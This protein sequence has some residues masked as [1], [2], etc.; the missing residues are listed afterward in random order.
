MYDPHAFL[1]RDP[2]ELGEL[3]LTGAE[4]N[5]Q[6]QTSKKVESK[7]TINA[8]ARRQRVAQHREAPTV[9]PQCQDPLED[10][11]RRV[12]DPASSGHLEPVWNQRRIV[13][14]GNEQPHIHHR[15]RGSC[16]EGQLEHAAS[17][18]SPQFSPDDDQAALRVEGETR[19]TIAVS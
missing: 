9:L 13:A 14:H 11:A 3:Y 19:S 15:A 12:L 18:R 1:G 16:I 6:V 7:Q 2:A 10:D 4:I 17:A 8:C 5:G